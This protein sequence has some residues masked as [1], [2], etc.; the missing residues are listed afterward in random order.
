MEH[1]ELKKGSTKRRKEGQGG[2]SYN[3]EKEWAGIRYRFVFQITLAAKF[4]TV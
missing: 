1:R 3:G 2:A 4:S